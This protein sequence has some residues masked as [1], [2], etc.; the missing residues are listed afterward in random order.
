MKYGVVPEFRDEYFFLSNFFPASF[1]WRR[2]EF[3]TGEHAFSYAKGFFC[4]DLVKQK[5]HFDNVLTAPTPNK[6][7]Y[8]GRSVK[9]NVEEWDKHK[10]MYMREIVHARFAQNTSNV[11][12][13]GKLINTGAMMLVEGNDWGDKFWGRAL[14]KD[15]GKR[16]GYNTLGALLMEERGYW[17]KGHL[18]HD[19]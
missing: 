18:T 7:K 8:Y 2:I 6:A 17:L 10:I 14:D 11:D 16:V 3:P 19:D 4:N 1:I 13:V 9:I 12:M 15:T 5:Q